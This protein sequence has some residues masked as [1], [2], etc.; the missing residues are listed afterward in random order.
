VRER[1]TGRI[2]GVGSTSGTRVV[3]GRWDDGPWGAFADLMVED[4]AGH[5]VLVAPDG[6]T[7]D[8]VSAT[9]AFD[10]VVIAPVAVRD[11]ADGWRVESDPLEL[12]LTI[13][14]PTAV[15]RLLRLVPPRVA[16]APAW[17]T[18][19]DPVA[20][21]VLRGVRTR[22]SAG[23]DRR[24]WYGATAAHAVT[25][26]RGTWRGADLGALARVDPPWR[27][28]VSSTPRRPSVTDVVT[29]VE[30]PAG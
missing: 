22:G 16:T 14:R 26:L 3:V 29:T 2:A 30:R 24:E 1:F 13:G 28:G 17:S 21:F 27:F 4:A 9:Y 19:T 5:R 18:L 7:R 8:F 15:G 10:E 25:A 20:R 11:T 12:T 23:R 6:R